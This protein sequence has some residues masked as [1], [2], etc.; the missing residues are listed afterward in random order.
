MSQFTAALGC[1]AD[2]IS[3]KTDGAQTHPSSL[4]TPNT[5]RSLRVTPCPLVIFR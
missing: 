5:P 3:T 2:D 1:K 4:M